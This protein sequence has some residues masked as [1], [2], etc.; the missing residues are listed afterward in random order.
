MKDLGY[1]EGYAYDP[2]YAHPVHNEFLPPQF[3]GVE[4]L[5]KEGDDSQKVWDEDLLLRWEHLENQGK[6]WEGKKK[7][8]GS[9]EGSQQHP[10][11]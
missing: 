1:G 9:G 8:A 3:K 4:F 2:E 6:D 11:T 7:A 10:N 5:G